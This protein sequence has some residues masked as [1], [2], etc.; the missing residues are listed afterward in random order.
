MSM[1]FD[2]QK[3]WRESAAAAKKAYLYAYVKSSNLRAPH[4][5]KGRHFFDAPGGCAGVAEHDVNAISR[6]CFSVVAVYSFSCAARFF[7]APFFFFRDGHEED[8]HRFGR[9][10]GRRSR[11]DFARES[12]RFFFP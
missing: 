5:K 7:F 9:C 10:C 6:C 1:V 2:H 3:V 11:C 4:K 12:G 8:D